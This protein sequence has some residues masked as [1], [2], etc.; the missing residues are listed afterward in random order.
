MKIQFSCHFLH[1]S[2]VVS[3]SLIFFCF[4]SLPRQFLVSPKS[5]LISPPT[6][7]LAA[8]VEFC[9]VFKFSHFT[10]VGIVNQ[11]LSH[12]GFPVSCSVF[13]REIRFFCFLDWD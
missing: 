6:L 3:T 10:T 9:P 2:S 4:P 8:P 13:L 11:M 5:E 1:F 7:L 12:A